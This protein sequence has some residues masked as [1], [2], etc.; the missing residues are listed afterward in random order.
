MHSR[1]D[2][3]PQR[4]FQSLLLLIPA[5]F[6]GLRSL[7]ECIDL[8]LDG[9]DPLRV[10]VLGLVQHSMRLVDRLLTAFTLLLPGGLFL[11]PFQLAAP[12]FPF[13]VES[14]LSFRSLVAGARGRLFHL[15]AF[16]LPGGFRWSPAAKIG[17]QLGVFAERSVR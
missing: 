5:G 10:L 2:R 11:R 17:G 1:R 3:A 15:W 7:L 6:F 13:L 8:G 12:P 16:R 4:S 14:G 9:G